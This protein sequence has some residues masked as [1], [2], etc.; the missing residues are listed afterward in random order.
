[1]MEVCTVCCG[2]NRIA[3]I[4][5]YNGQHRSLLG[6]KRRGI[7]GGD[8]QIDLGADQLLDEAFQVIDASA[9]AEALENQVLA[10]RVASRSPDC[11]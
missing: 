10:R 5:G 7:G 11:E 8:D 9:Y 2:R 1:M 3:G 6:S 4:V